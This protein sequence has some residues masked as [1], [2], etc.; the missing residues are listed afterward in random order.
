MYRAGIIHD[1]D[2]VPDANERRACWYAKAATLGLV[3]LGPRSPKPR[4]D[5]VLP[6]SPAAACVGEGKVLVPM[7]VGKVLMLR[8]K[9][10]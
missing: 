3:V 10:A 8:R 6:P 1:T 4:S 9:S 5:V 7:L 2:R